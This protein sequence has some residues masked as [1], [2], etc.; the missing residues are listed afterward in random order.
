MANSDQTSQ[1][2]CTDQADDPDCIG[3]IR[4]K[5]KVIMTFTGKQ[6]FFCDSFEII[7]IKFIT[8]D[9]NVMIFWSPQRLGVTRSKVKVTAP[10]NIETVP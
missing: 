3:V 7:L 1:D 4:S 2:D 5:V 10:V 8:L 6:L 9:M